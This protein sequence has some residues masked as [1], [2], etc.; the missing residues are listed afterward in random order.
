M[1]IIVNIKLLFAPLSW[2]ACVRIYVKIEYVM[3][4]GHF[5]IYLFNRKMTTIDFDIGH[6]DAVIKG[7]PIFFY[8]YFFLVKTFP[9]YIADG[10]IVRKRVLQSDFI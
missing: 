1:V 8:F 2:P 4:Q 7:F 3:K 9:P 10:Y 6:L 5:K